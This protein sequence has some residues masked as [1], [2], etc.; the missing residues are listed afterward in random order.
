MWI[1]P[2]SICHGPLRDLLLPSVDGGHERP[3]L[4][5][6]ESESR[7]TYVQGLTEVPLHDAAAAVAL[8]RRALRM[9]A[10]RATDANARSS[11]SHAVLQLSQI[12]FS[13][14][15]LKQTRSSD[16]PLAGRVSPTPPL[17][18][19]GALAPPCMT[20]SVLSLTVGAQAAALPAASPTASRSSRAAASVSH[21]QTGPAWRGVMQ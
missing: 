15:I 5:L 10:I 20:Q 2:W 19:I 16:L 14:H 7:E 1:L 3:A 18:A 8:I 4:A 11:R 13:Q 6:R 21:T 12:P 9:R 17:I